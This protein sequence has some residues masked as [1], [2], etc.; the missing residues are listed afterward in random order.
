MWQELNPIITTQ[1]AYYQPFKPRF[2]N[3]GSNRLRFAGYSE[4]LSRCLSGH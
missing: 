3:V 2:F 4:C 1:E